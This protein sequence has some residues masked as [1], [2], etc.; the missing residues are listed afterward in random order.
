L[1]S[2]GNHRRLD[3]GDAGSD[4]PLVGRN[5]FRRN[6]SL[7][8][9]VRD[10]SAGRVHLFRRRFGL[11]RRRVLPSRARPLR[12][13]K[14]AILPIGAY[15]PRWFMRRSAHESRRG[16]AGAPDCGAETALASHFGTFQL[17]DE[18]IDAPP[19]ALADALKV[20]A[21]RP[22]ASA[23]HGPGQVWHTASNLNLIT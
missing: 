8:G 12:P 2:A 21:F 23:H 5:L 1:G 22:N 17:T 3:C 13:F 6:M 20:A 19:L 11:W 9:V 16:R 4:T 15:E 10:R 14:L 18:A 7:M